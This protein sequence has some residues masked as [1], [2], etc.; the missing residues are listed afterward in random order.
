MK[1]DEIG[2]H[3]C[4]TQPRDGA[5]II[6]TNHRNVFALRIAKYWIHLEVSSR[7]H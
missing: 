7:C 3:G 6:D 4:A 5:K 2:W 1:V